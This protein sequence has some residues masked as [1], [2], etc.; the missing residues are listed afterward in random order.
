MRPRLVFNSRLCEWLHVDAI[1]LFPFIFFANGVVTAELFRH[2]MKHWEQ[3]LKYWV[4]G[5]YMI[6]LFHYFKNR[7]LGMSHF[8]A[9]F[10]ITFEVEARK[11]ERE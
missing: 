2:E 5:F 4:V 9:Y 11:A 3:C 7:A 8:S 10:W 1:V 6:Y